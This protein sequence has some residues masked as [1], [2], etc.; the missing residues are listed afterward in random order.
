MG[1]QQFLTVSGGAVVANGLGVIGQHEAIWAAVDASPSSLMSGSDLAGWETALGDGV[2]T[3]TGQ[4]PVDIADIAT[5]HSGTHSTLHA[6][7]VRRGVMAHNITHK[8]H[9]DAT[10]FDTVHV[11]QYAFRLPY[12]PA[13]GAWPDNA[14]TAEGGLFVWDGPNTQLDYGLAFQW[15]LNPWMPTSGSI[16]CWTGTRWTNTGFLAVDTNWHTVSMT[17]DPRHSTAA[18]SIDGVAVPAALA[19][20]TKVG[21][22]SE[23]AARLHTEVIS[24]WPGSNHVAPSHRLEIRDWTWARYL[25]LADI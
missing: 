7:V 3:A 11:A 15:V 18:L 24:L 13:A 23:V 14:Q 21:F 17:Y 1:R 20:T 22:G 8:R 16:R 25:Y 6:N 9:V 2:Y 12:M 10:A 19:T 5:T 4:A